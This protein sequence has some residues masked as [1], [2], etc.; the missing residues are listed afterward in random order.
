M[1]CRKRRA[2]HL[3]FHSPY[4][5]TSAVIQSSVLLRAGDCMLSSEIKED[6][7]QAYAIFV[8]VAPAS[9]LGKRALPLLTK[10]RQSF[11]ERGLDS[12][13]SHTQEPSQGAS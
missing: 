2:A 6:F 8:E 13:R 5:F 3:N 11:S 10:L 7:E 9:S 12:H 1:C 4:S